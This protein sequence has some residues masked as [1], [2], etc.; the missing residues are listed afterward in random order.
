MRLPRL[1]A[2]TLVTGALTLPAVAPALAVPGPATSI[3]ASAKAPPGAFATLAT[4]AAVADPAHRPGAGH[5]A[6]Q[7]ALDAVVATGVPG[8]VAEVRDAH[9]TWTGTAG[10]ADLRHRGL[11]PA[12]A[13]FRAGSVTKTFVATTVLQ[14][15]AEHRVRLDAP[16]ERY[17]PHV[18]P[19]GRH[20]TVRDLLGHRSGLHDYTDALW[21]AGLAQLYRTRFRHWTPGE[22]LAAAFRHAP[23]FAPGSAGQYSNTNY[24]VL[25][26]LLEKVTGQSAEKEITDRVIAPLGL[27]HTY[28]PGGSVRIA[29]P[30]AHGYLPI[31]P[32][33]SP[34]A[35]ATEQNMSYAS[36]SLVSTAHDLNLFFRALIGGRLLPPSQL[37]AMRAVRPLRGGPAY[38]LGLSRLTGP[39]FGTAYGHTGGTPGYTTFAYTTADNTR[40]VTLSLNVLT[41][42]ARTRAAADAALRTLLH[43]PPGFR[44]P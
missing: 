16:V 7:R 42:S 11:P 31:G 38:G 18:V 19:D 12:D 3:P 27:R 8:V 28:F 20:I 33:G 23:E 34:L 4:R 17:L 2:V 37:D 9:G 35:D 32:A 30:H 24:V 22:L 43:R 5:P 40:Q 15:V 25:G 21:H 44:T 1:A 39:S 14:L 26:R 6:W 36:G 41:D 10:R 13:R 29:G